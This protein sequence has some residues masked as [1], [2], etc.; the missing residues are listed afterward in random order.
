MCLLE[1][2]NSYHTAITI[3]YSPTSSKSIITN[4]LSSRLYIFIS[5]SVNNTLLNK[6]SEIAQILSNK[7]ITKTLIT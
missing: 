1:Y 3:K 6:L 4:N 5:T 2:F 7:I